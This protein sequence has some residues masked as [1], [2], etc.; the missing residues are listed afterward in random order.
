[1]KIVTS[2]VAVASVVILA[3]GLCPCL[4]SVLLG[5]DGMAAVLGGWPTRCAWDW[6]PNETDPCACLRTENGCVCSPQILGMECSDQYLDQGRVWYCTGAQSGTR[7]TWDIS[8][9]CGSRWQCHCDTSTGLCD[10][11]YRRIDDGGHYPSS[12]TCLDI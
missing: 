2:T 5:D 3:L 8:G 1:M 4:G 11:F 9:I 10:F 6:C 7:C 12:T